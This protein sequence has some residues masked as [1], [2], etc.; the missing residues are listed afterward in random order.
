MKFFQIALFA[1]AAAN[2][3]R[4]NVNEEPVDG[5]KKAE[6]AITSAEDEAVGKFAFKKADEADRMKQIN[7]TTPYEKPKSETISEE[8]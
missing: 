1:V 5:E 6:K 2:A 3:I 7:I 8:W 4:I